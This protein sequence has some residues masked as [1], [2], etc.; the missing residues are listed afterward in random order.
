MKNIDLNYIGFD[1]NITKETILKHLTQEQIFSYYI[2]EDVTKDNLFHSPLR[3]DNIPSFSTYY[4]K[5][6][7]NLLMFKDWATNDCG[8]FVELVRKKEGLSF[9]DALWK[10]VY[11]FGLGYINPNSNFNNSITI[12]EKA[13]IKDPIKLGIKIRAWNIEDKEYWGEYNI[14][15]KTLEKFHVFPIS[16][17]FF[18][19][20]AFVAAKLAYCYAENKDDILSYKIYQPKEIKIKKWINNTKYCVHQ[21]YTQLP[22]NGKLLII[23][24]SLK[25]VMCIYNNL[26]IP[27]IGLQSESISVKD[28]VMEEYKRRFKKIICLFDNDEAGQKAAVNFSNKFDIPFIMIPKYKNEVK[29]F[30]DLVKDKGINEAQKILK[31]L[32]RN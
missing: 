28:I 13:F 21:G 17:I 14:N 19:N 4:H 23:T 16:H 3:E 20:K 10:I 11:D 15:R 26:L 22:E 18:N 32:I 5:N 2:G 7:Q 12:N 31:K 1:P 25:D 6:N 24:K 27:S 8:D 9:K 29:D 30:S